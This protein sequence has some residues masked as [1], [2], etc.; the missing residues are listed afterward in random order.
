MTV[1]P[2]LM[3]ICTFSPRL[4]EIGN[5]VRGSLLTAMLACLL[6]SMGCSVSGVFGDQVVNSL[7]GW[8][9]NTRSTTILSKRILLFLLICIEQLRV[10]CMHWLC[11]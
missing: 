9:Q 7:K 8:P 10:S 6:S 11:A 1:I 2:G 3:G 4:N 5:S